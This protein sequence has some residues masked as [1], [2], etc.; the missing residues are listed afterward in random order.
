MQ[1]YDSHEDIHTAVGFPICWDQADQPGWEW[2]EDHGAW[3]ELAYVLTND[4]GLIVFVAD[5]P[6]TDFTLRFNL[7]GVANRPGPSGNK[8]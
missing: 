5:D 2:M 3:F 7:L 1:P 6:S 8:P 4:L